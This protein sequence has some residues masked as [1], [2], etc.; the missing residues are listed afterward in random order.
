VRRLQADH[1]AILARL[2]RAEQD[3]QDSMRERIAAD[4]LAARE[5]RELRD[6]Y[7]AGYRKLE[8]KLDGLKTWALVTLAALVLNLMIFIVS[9]MGKVLGGLGPR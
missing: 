5:H 2:L 3:L 1:A 7:L 8:E 4:A 9:Q 6:E